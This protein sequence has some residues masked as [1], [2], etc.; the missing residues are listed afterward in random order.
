MNKNIKILVVEDDGP[1]RNL[2]STALQTNQYKYDLSVNGEK[3]LLSLSTHHYDI[4]LLDLGLPDKDGIE[5]IEQFRTFSMTPVI[6]I[7]ARSS[8]EDKIKALDAGAD[9]YI[10]KPFSVEELL[11]RVRSTLRRSQYLENQKGKEE[12][13]FINGDLKID[14]PSRTVFFQNEE[15]HLMPIEYN[16]L[17]LLAK[18]VGKVLTHQYILDKV[19]TNALESDLSSLRVYMT[20][21][22]KKIEKKSEQKYIQTH[23]GVG[24]KM[25]K[26][27]DSKKDK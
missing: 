5:I 23:I 1:I 16:L 10:T 8:D 6:V 18:N 4:V 9:D 12:L 3:A 20:S 25:I 19:W 13:I 21:L 27:N 22:R 26:M 14:Y 2:I 24:Y 11:A 15:I 17:C 7:S